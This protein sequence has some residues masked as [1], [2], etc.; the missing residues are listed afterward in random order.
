MI[1]TYV[2]ILFYSKYLNRTNGLLLYKFF[3]E[4]W[5]IQNSY[6]EK[7]LVLGI[8]LLFVGIFF[9]P[10]TIIKSR[11]FNLSNNEE[12]SNKLNFQNNPPVINRTFPIDGAKN[13]SISGKPVNVEIYDADNDDLWVEIWSNH[14]GEW[15]EYAGFDLINRS[16][17]SIFD[18]A[19]SLIVVDFN[20]DGLWNLLDLVWLTNREGWGQSGNWGFYDNMSVTDDWGMTSSGTIYYWSVNISDKSAWTNETYHFTTEITVTYVDDDFNE[21]TPGWE[22]DHFDNIQDG[23]DTVNE[24][25][26]VCVYNGTYYENIVV[27]KSVKLV[28]E[29][30]N[31]TVI[32]GSGNGDV[33]YFS[34]NWIKISGFTIQNSGNSWG[35][36]CLDITSNY[37]S[38]NG[39][40]INND[41]SSFFGVYFHEIS[42]ENKITDNIIE[43]CIEDGI[44]LSESSDN[45]T[46]SENFIINN[47]D[48][49]Q[50]FEVSGNI[51]SSNTIFN[52]DDDGIST[53]GSS[54]DN[55]IYG[56]K[57]FNNSDIGIYIGGSSNNTITGNNISLNNGD[58]INLSYSNNN[59]I[60]G[61]IILNNENGI[62]FE[63]SSNNNTIYHNNLIS[64]TMNAVDEC[65]NTW[66]NPTIGEGNYWDDYNGTDSDKDGIGDTPYNISG[67][68]N[69]DLYP[70][71]NIFGPPYAEFEYIIDRATVQF[72]ASKSGDYNGYIISYEWDF[73]DGA[74]GN[75]KIVSH[76]YSNVGT[77]DVHLTVQDN[78]GNVGNIT[79]SVVIDEIHQPP[80]IPTINGPSYGQP[81]VLYTFC[82][83]VIDP[84]GD[85]IYCKWDWGDGTFTDWIGPYASGEIIC[86]SHGWIDTGTY[87]IKVKLKDEYGLETGWSE[88]LIIIIEGEE[89]DVKITMPEKRTFYLNIG[90]RIM[91]EVPC[92]F[93]LIIGKINIEVDA[94]D[95]ISGIDKV[96]FYIDEDLKFNDTEEPFNWI[97]AERAFFRHKIKVVV[98]DNAGNSA[99][100]EIRIRKFF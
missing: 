93:T 54:K 15:V 8:I 1:V 94:S 25:R 53:S 11:N 76:T 52:N 20:E 46:V 49:I 35:D 12:S 27:D 19:S 56:N 13:I 43:G 70:L 7:W 57:V 99:S 80:N 41:G 42:L 28:G 97:W 82:I 66:Q 61:N 18:D 81:G 30:R 2:A 84:N 89:P 79:K 33:I 92:F 37:N 59:T 44:Y 86:S 36:A 4:S 22:F 73:D 62:I 88:P 38:I 17:K 3:R 21:S 16:R 40:I 72:D 68:D 71:M 65:S 55:S 29:D 90:D 91:L 85:N 39:N 32:D 31:N 98:F 50:L 45:N 64:N 63:C 95:E 34:A 24:N 100:D 96:E 78:D 60:I 14:T 48:G 6:W 9:S 69:Q 47:H 77:Y 58:G 67:S 75:G 83:G 10:V 26:T 51:I 87:E 5:D 23:I 74:I